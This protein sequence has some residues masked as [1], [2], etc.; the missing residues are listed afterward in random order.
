MA[1]Q[2]GFQ[3][4]VG[5]CPRQFNRL[6]HAQVADRYLFHA[7]NHH[8]ATLLDTQHQTLVVQIEKVANRFQSRTD[9]WLVTT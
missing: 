2:Q 3:Q 1:A 5:H 9:S 4:A 6:A 7:Q 8:A